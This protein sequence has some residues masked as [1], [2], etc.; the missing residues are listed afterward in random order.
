[1]PIRSSSPLRRND[2]ALECSAKAPSGTQW[3][4]WPTVFSRC[5]TMEILDD[6]KRCLNIPAGHDCSTFYKKVTPSTHLHSESCAN[7][8]IR[9]QP[10][11][12][13]VQ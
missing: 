7:R 4:Y 1:M 8:S 3:I 5:N 2:L 13:I 9:L 10:V 6:G 12:Q 11:Q